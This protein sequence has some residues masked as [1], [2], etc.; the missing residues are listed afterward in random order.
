MKNYFDYNYRQEHIHNEANRKTG[1][2]AALCYLERAK[3]FR[4]NWQFLFMSIF[5]IAI[6]IL[7]AVTNASACD[8]GDAPG[9]SD[10][11]AAADA[12]PS[13]APSA[14]PAA[15][16]AAA[17]APSAAPSATAP[18]ISP[19]PIGGVDSG[20][21]DYDLVEP[22]KPDCKWIIN[23]WCVNIIAPGVWSVKGHPRGE[24][25]HRVDK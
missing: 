7:L 25:W 6:L 5:A 24:I 20:D 15:A 2:D 10:A 12:A 11:P 23:G 18:G 9:S 16:L 8:P 4:F 3:S 17:A 22:A 19:D 21:R 13:A 1:A 14:A